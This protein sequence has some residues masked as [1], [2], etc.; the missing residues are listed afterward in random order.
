MGTTLDI[1]G[2]CLGVLNC[3][4]SM[5]Q[6]V[7]CVNGYSL[8]NNICRYAKNDCSNILANGLCGSCLNGYILN[9]FECVSNSTNSISP[10]SNFI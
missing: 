3:L 10:N 7:H 8:Q 2:N 9:G 6:C 4:V 5:K 1:N